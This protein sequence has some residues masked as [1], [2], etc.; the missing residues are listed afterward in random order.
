MQRAQL[1]G[2]GQDGVDDDRHVLHVLELEMR[3]VVDI[4]VRL[5]DAVD[6][7][8][9]P[10]RAV[11]IAPQLDA[12]PQP[13]AHATT[14]SVGVAPGSTGTSSGWACRVAPTEARHTNPGGAPHA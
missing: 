5:L 2:A 10:G 7:K 1:F 8:P 13:R 12:A 3:R 14:S 6:E 11:G 9:P 4:D